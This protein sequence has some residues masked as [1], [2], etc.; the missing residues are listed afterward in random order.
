MLSV[1]IENHTFD[2]CIVFKGSAQHRNGARASEARVTGIGLKVALKQFYSGSETFFVNSNLKA[3]D[4]I[5]S[6]YTVVKT[7]P[8]QQNF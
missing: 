3:C 7:C 2:R 1:I 8:Q 4:A 6:Y 5:T